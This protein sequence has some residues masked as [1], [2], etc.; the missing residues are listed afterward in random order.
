MSEQRDIEKL[1]AAISSVLI[2][3]RDDETIHPE[4]VAASVMVTLN[5]QL[6]EIAANLEIRQL[7]R[8]MLRRS[9]DADADDTKR[10]KQ[11]PTLPGLP[12]V[13]ERYPKMPY[14]HGYVKRDLMSKEDWRG[15]VERLRGKG[16]K[17][18]AHA[19]QLEEWGRDRYEE[20]IGSAMSSSSTA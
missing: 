6:K 20:V 7:V 17:L 18:I 2:K 8:A 4:V 11:Q 16:G 14:G 9:Y 5:Q 3:H 1:N 15:N 19:D 10:R 12:L 13:Q